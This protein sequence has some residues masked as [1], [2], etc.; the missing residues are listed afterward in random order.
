MYVLD[1]I[2]LLSMNN[3]RRI[4]ANSDGADFTV[5]SIHVMNGFGDLPRRATMFIRDPYL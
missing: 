4:M 2:V 3:P 1:D 5:D